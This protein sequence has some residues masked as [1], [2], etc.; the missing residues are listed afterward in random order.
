VAL[1]QRGDGGRT[2]QRGVT[3]QHEHVG[4][5]EVD[6]V[7]GERGEPDADRIAGA[8]LHVLLHEVEQQVGVLLLELLGDALG[9]VTHDHHGAPRGA[10]AQRVEDVHQHR[11]AAQQV[12]RLGAVGP[13]AGALARRQHDG[14]QRTHGDRLGWACVRHGHSSRSLF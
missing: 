7:I 10:V 1:H 3:R 5:V 14:G 9:A 13:H 12:Q 11:L 6:L 4:V 2:Q 8:A